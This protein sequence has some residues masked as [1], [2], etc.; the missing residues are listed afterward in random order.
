MTDLDDL[1]PRPKLRRDAFFAALDDGGLAVLNSRGHSVHP[2]VGFGRW[3]ERLAPFLD[4]THTVEE[5]T[6][7]LTAERRDHVVGVL[8]R[9]GRVGVL[10]HPRTPSAAAAATLTDTEQRIYAE[11]IRY[12]AEFEPDAPARFAVHRGTTLAVVGAGRI[13]TALLEALLLNGTR[14]ITVVLTDEAVTD[15][16]QLGAVITAATERD[17]RQRVVVRRLPW[18][19]LPKPDRAGTLAS[20]LGEVDLVLHAPDGPEVDVAQALESLCADNGRTFLQTTVLSD[21]A[22]IFLSEPRPDHAGW[23]AAWLRIARQAEADGP[24]WPGPLG[25]Q[26][27]LDV[28]ATAVLAN[29]IAL[30]L[31]GR[32]T[33]IDP[34]G[35]EVVRRI[36]LRT[37]A[38]SS[39]SLLPHPL[40]L[41][42]R[43]QTAQEFRAAVAAL[44]NRPAMDDEEFS[45]AA[46]RCLDKR[47]GVLRAIDERHFQQIP[48]WVMEASVGP[49]V[50]S[51]HGEVGLRRVY[52]ADLEF[53][54]A[55][56][57]TARS[58]LE[59]Y[60]SGALD[61]RR[62]LTDDASPLTSSQNPLRDGWLWAWRLDGRGEC[63]VPASSV[64]D[65]DPEP[66]RLPFGVASGPTW[67]AAV[68]R[69]LLS[70][71]EEYAVTRAP[72]EQ[73]PVPEVDLDHAP[74][75]EIGHRLL[76]ILRLVDADVRSYDVSSWLGIPLYGIILDGEPIAYAAGSTVTQ[77]LRDGLER[78]VLAYQA[79]S[80]GQEEYAPAGVP[81][82]NT[83][84]DVVT[85]TAEPTP[86]ADAA[87]RVSRLAHVLETRVGTPAAVPLDHDPAVLAALPHA[88][89]VVITGR[90]IREGQPQ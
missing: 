53:L 40:A 25:D 43:P 13:V 29:T 64:F 51:P 19:H 63:L 89:R 57:R 39:H 66:A 5:L 18:R 54:P 23:Q 71:C 77:A 8:E 82:L 76:G 7:S 80:T 21:E 88:L 17:R 55:R 41:P 48:L 75:D 46:A 3:V 58:G 78:A 6:R 61:E 33:G 52:G 32:T 44:E 69:G 38:S 83:S 72:T 36:D 4:G 45:T 68:E 74:L 59:L 62:L 49:S 90:T 37:L 34:K 67:L 47:V 70:R 30:R 27:G 31:F 16:E 26:E 9:L 20:A 2:G 12:L 60:L 22:V 85:P 84:T 28:G 35:P 50:A 14:D 24:T 15:S 73:R 11:Q 10:E 87:E 81:N 56:Y 42:A 86:P 1:G 79:R 65:P